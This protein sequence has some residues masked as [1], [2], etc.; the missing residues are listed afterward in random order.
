MSAATPPVLHVAPRRSRPGSARAPDWSTMQA[1]LTKPANAKVFLQRAR[2]YDA[3]ASPDATA[4]LLTSGSIEALA[5]ASVASLAIAERVVIDVAHGQTAASPRRSLLPFLATSRG[6]SD[7]IV[8]YVRVLALADR[9]HVNRAPS[10]HLRT[11]VVLADEA[12]YRAGRDVAAKARA[13]LSLSARANV[14]FAFPDEPWANLDLEA[15]LADPANAAQYVRIGFLLSAASD[16]DVVKRFLATSRAHYEL[17]DVAGDLAATFPEDEVL[18]LLEDGLAR[19]LKKPKYGAV[20]KTQPRRI[21]ETVAAIGTP[22]AARVLARFAS[23]PILAT[24]ILA[25][26]R[27]HPEHT[28]VLESV[29]GEGSKLASTA[30]RIADKQGK[31]AVRARAAKDAELPSILRERPWTQ[32]PEASDVIEGLAQKGMELERLDDELLEM[33]DDEESEVRHA[34]PMTKTELVAWREKLS[35]RGFLHADYE[36]V[37]T[38]NG[39]WEWIEVPAADGLAAWG[40]ERIDAEG[41]PHDV[42]TS[43]SVLSFLRRHGVAAFA[44]WIRRDWPSHLPWESGPDAMHASRV[45]VSPAIAPAMAHVLTDRKQHRHHARAWLLRHSR[46]AALG[47]VPDALGPLGAARKSAEAALVMMATAGEREAVEKAANAYGAA[48][49]KG[50]AALLARDPRR[51]D[52]AVPKRPSILKHEDLPPIRL[53]DSDAILG[54]AAIESVLDMLSLSLPEEPYPGLAELSASLDVASLGAF[55]LELLE[56][57]ALGDA[58]GRSEWMGF[59]VIHLPSPEGHARLA[60]FAREQS[61]KNQAKCE[62]ACVALAEIG[63]DLTLLHLSRIAN[64]TRFQKLKSRAA[65]LLAQ[66]AA[67]RGLGVDELEDRTVP[68]VDGAD[69]KERARVRERVVRRLEQLLITGRSL[70]REVF[71]SFFV[72]QPVVGPLARTLLWETEDAAIPFRIA[73]D[74]SFADVSDDT[75]TLPPSTRVRLAHPARAPGLPAAWAERFAEYE[76]LQAIDQ[77]G[78]RAHALGKKDARKSTL[79]LASST[80]APAKKLMGLLES[81]GWR[82]NSAG[83]PSA[84]LRDLGDVRITLPITPGFEVRDLAHADAQSIGPIT[85]TRKREPLTLGDLDPVT[86]SETVRDAEAASALGT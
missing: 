18:P 64:G 44:G 1:W 31:K 53:R 12:S 16:L 46:V 85:F 27:D 15:W 4:A 62:R 76:I 70:D 82:R 74:G 36:H 29:A 22:E 56:Q 71:E 73:E 49:R 42:Y 63:S 3:A 83:N 47:L 84:F 40:T 61:T 35:K 10:D 86:L 32:K 14:A 65:E 34:R 11:A 5:K 6:L 45:I 7:A 25:W 57:W 81:R 33:L 9:H 26:F 20:L 79:D 54:P 48:A 50:I 41:K 8:I 21:A 55:A 23:H 69:A 43:A 17:P 2:S 66:A 13:G 30:Q 51:I 78:R 39:S 68:D 37:K 72:K 67:M 77:L 52:R 19:F 24:Q 60:S 80:K 75:I 38:A 59:S 28:A 58:P